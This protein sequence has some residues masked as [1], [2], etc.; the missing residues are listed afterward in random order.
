MSGVSYSAGVTASAGVTRAAGV[1]EVSG[2]AQ[3]SA[4]TRVSTP[5]FSPSPGGYGPTQSVTIHCATAGASIRYTTNGT[6]PTSTSGTV[7]TGAV[8][9]SVTTTLKAIAYNGVLTDSAV[10][11]GVFTINGQVATPSISPAAGSYNNDQTVSITCATGGASIYYTT[12]GTTPDNTKTLYAGAF[13]L[14]ASATVKAIGIKGGYTDSAVASNAITLQAAT[15]TFSPSAGSYGSAQSV[16]ISSSTTGA[17]IYYTTDGSTPTTGSTLYTVPVSV[18]SS[19]TLKALAVKSGYGD[20]SVGSA[21]YTISGG[22]FISATGGTVT[23]DGNYKI[24]T[25]TS[26]GNL[27]VTAGGTLDDYLI[28]GGGGGGGNDVGGGGG[29]GDVRSSATDGPMSVTATTYPITVG[30]GGPGSSNSSPASNGND[31]AFNGLTAIGGGGAASYGG[32][33]NGLSGGSGGGAAGYIG[34]I[35]VGGT[36]TGV[37]GHDGGANSID[38][39]AATGGA[40]GGAGGAGQDSISN[41]SGFAEGGLAI[42]SAITGSAVSYAKGGRGAGDS[43]SGQTNPTTANTGNGGDGSGANPEHGIAGAD[44]VVIVRYRFQ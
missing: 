10:A 23:T 4:S 7:Y 21:A 42:S 17:S 39:G 30:A 24:H 20:S 22:S 12:D 8:S 1:T 6:D 13:T 37:Q 26:S 2:V 16:T 44:G 36:A 28:V 5:T 38:T 18:G 14:G 15:P 27:V 43:W 34:A 29:A 41:A 35:G 3:T 33:R 31:S 9:V 25:F 40:G 19:L 32:A 11:T